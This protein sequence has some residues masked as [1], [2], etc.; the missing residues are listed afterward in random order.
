MKLQLA[1]TPDSHTKKPVMIQPTSFTDEEY[2]AEWQRFGIFSKTDAAE[3]RDAYFYPSE[4]SEWIRNGFSLEESA[5]WRR[6]KHG[7]ESA[8][9]LRAEGKTP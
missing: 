6:T 2:K 5:E 4:A 1:G 7:V 8:T 9:R 3:W